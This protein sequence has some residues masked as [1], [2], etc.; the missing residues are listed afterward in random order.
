MYVIALC[1]KLQHG[2]YQTYR[3]GPDSPVHKY[4]YYIK[5]LVRRVRFK[6]SLIMVL[7][8]TL[9]EEKE[10]CKGLYSETLFLR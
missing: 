7:C 3:N 5:A 2:L 1:R 8:D 9:T 6:L 10:N 4:F